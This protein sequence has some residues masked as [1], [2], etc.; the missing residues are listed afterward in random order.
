MSDRGRVVV[1]FAV[2]ALIAG[3]AGFYF[4]KVHQPAQ[5][6][7]GAQEE[8]VAWEA[9]YQQARDCLLGKSPGSTKTSEA[10]AIREMAPD[11]WDRGKCT[12]LVSKL[13]RGD[14]NDTGVAAVE[15]AWIQL[16]KA[17]Q[18]A[19]LSFANHVAGIAKGEAPLP[20]ALDDLDV[21][22]GNLRS[23][24]KLPAT[25]QVGTALSPVQI[26]P[27]LDGN[28][29]VTSL[30][31]ET[32][33]SAHGYVLFGR[34]Q[35]REVQVVLTGGAAPKVARLGSGSIRA[36]P[37]LS[38]GATGSR[39][40]VRGKGKA[41]DTTGTVMAG[42]M[43]TEG[44]IASPSTLTLAAPLVAEGNLFDAAGYEPG[45]EV[46]SVMLAAVSGSLA[47]GALVYGA[48]ETLVVAHANANVVT[49]GPP[50]KIEVAMASTDVDGRVALVW[51]TLAKENRAALLAADG[52]EQLY[53]LPA[54]FLGAPCMTKDRVWI[55]A[56]DPE[57]YSFG[58]GR[59]L[60]RIE[61]E[62]S[63]GLLGCT[64]DAA[65]ARTHDRHRDISVCTDRCRTATIPSSAPSYATVTAVGGKLYAIA[66]HGGVVGVWSE[67]KPPVFYS[68][69]PKT[70]PAYAKDAP[71]MALTDGKVIDVLADAGNQVLLRIPVP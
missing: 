25:T 22:R 29:P 7:K 9:R 18:K 37:D 33:P 41:Q 24:A 23:V 60:A 10:L 43:D 11:P 32:I 26:I 48:T 58:G 44:A 6:L 49:A 46:G 66:A 65:L 21:A 40:V 2:V 69:P 51:T 3:G 59:P 62:S 19:A 55:M 70:M 42:A 68:V 34:T 64:A 52:S 1:I 45:D 57:L 38:W 8:I 16:D 5:E 67:D 53:E 14:A 28:E 56:L 15:A 17:A 61:L 71:A 30:R 54:R 27:I 63:S 13:S 12:P 36:V 39:L 4:F 35:S 50:I 47:R 31:A 20:T